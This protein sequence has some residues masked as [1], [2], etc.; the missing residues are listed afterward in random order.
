[1]RS[2]RDRSLTHVDRMMRQAIARHDA[3]LQKRAVRTVKEWRLRFSIREVAQ[4]LGVGH[5]T[6]HRWEQ[7]ETMPNLELAQDV[8]QRADVYLK[9]LI[10]NREVTD[11]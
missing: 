3:E 11:R 6:V 10:H 5:T 9:R 4:A 7:G 1:M 2:P 8:A